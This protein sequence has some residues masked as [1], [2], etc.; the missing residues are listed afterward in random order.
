MPAPWNPGEA[1]TIVIGLLAL[2]VGIGACRRI[3][4]LQRLNIPAPVIGGLAV[5]ALTLALYWASGVEVKFA[6]GL[7][8]ILLL[9]FFSTIGLSARLRA[10]R[11][12][13]WPLALLCLAVVVLLVVQN[14][15]G[16]LVVGAFG[17][18]PFYG[19][20]MGSASF[21]GGPGTAM[22]WA[23]EAQT[24]F[25]LE[26][27]PEIG[28]AAATVAV[29]SGALVAGPV[30]GWLV[31]RHGLGGA[32]AREAL[33]TPSGV[34]DPGPQPRPGAT[35]EQLLSGLLL[36]A[37]AVTAGDLLNG[38]ARAQ[39]QVLPGFL[40][41]MLAGV[42][43]GN[44]LDLAGRRLPVEG[45]EH[46]GEIALQVFL[47]LSLM[48]LRLWTVGGTILPMLVNAAVQ[49]V[50]SVAVAV[51]LLFRL[52]GRDYDAAVTAGGFLG[53]GLSSMPVAMATMEQ[54]ATRYGP[55][56]R[57]VLLITLCGSIFVDLVNA[58]VI[59]AF[60]W[61]PAFAQAGS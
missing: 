50:L 45:V 4:A 6:T 36:V 22:A 19:L 29:V 5:S 60:L 20:L 11:E 46:A 39:G 52:L 27:A 33:A 14:V 51:L 43:L 8:D 1:L 58:L 47:V 40:T 26:R 28:I 23:R 41:A 44:V 30:A 7:R 57:A 54:L 13:G 34:L 59:K 38:W 48:S 16:M 32:P 53:F 15:A 31:E 55:S 3:G 56:P 49:I 21:V 10:L 24:G 37:A 17:E 12:G 9:V 35:V 42:V 2:A 25:G 61:L 18:H